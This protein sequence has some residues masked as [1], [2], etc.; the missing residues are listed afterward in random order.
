MTPSS[1]VR[2]L[3]CRT[4]LFALALAMTGASFAA[5]LP[6]IGP[7]PLLPQDPRGFTPRCGTP[8]PAARAGAIGLFGIP[9]DCSATTTNPSG[10]YDPTV[11]YQIPVVVHIIMTSDCATGVISDA[12][13]QSQI[14]ILNEDFLALAGTNGENGTYSA[15]QFVLATTDPDGDPTTGI[16]R[17]CNTT[18]FNDGGSY[19]NTLAWDPNRYLNMYTNNGGGALGY[20]PFLP[21]DGG[22]TFVGTAGDRVVVLWDTFGRNAPQ[23]PFDLGRT[24]THEVGHYLGLEHTFTGGC[25]TATPPGC[26]SAGDL[27]CDTNPESSPTFGCPGSRTTCSVAAPFDNYMDYSD[28]I[29]ME[30]FTPEQMRR[31]RCSLVNYRPNLFTIVTPGDPLFD[32]GFESEDTSAW[33]TTVPAP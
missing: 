13:A 31:M 11:I 20:V 7:D 1:T 32:D 17:D 24:A 23:A 33:S 16:T 8:S 14:D 25:S 22:G 21:A 26:Y 3:V 5:E 2:H 27:I 15:I 18:W 9:S 6:P 29:C 4:T 10:D 19:W 30:K 28:D 12:M